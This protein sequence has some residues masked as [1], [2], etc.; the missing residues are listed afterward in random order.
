MVGRVCDEVGSPRRGFPV[1]I[2]ETI[3]GDHLGISFE[4]YPK[5]T[6]GAA[7]SPDGPC[8]FQMAAEYNVAAF[9]QFWHNWPEVLA[10]HPFILNNWAWDHFAFVSKTSGSRDFD[11]I[12]P[13]CPPQDPGA[14]TSWPPGYS[15]GAQRCGLPDLPYP[16]YVAL[17][18]TPKPL[19]ASLEPYRGSVGS[20]RGFLRRS[21]TGEPVKYG[22]VFTDGREFG[23]PSLFDGQYAI[24]DIPAGTYTLSVEKVGYRSE[25]TTVTVQEGQEAQVDF[26]LLFQGRKYPRAST[27]RTKA[28]AVA[29]TFLAP[30]WVRPSR[31]PTTWV[32]SNSL[33]AC[34]TSAT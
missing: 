20:I 19:P 6:R 3:Y 14:Q 12:P 25:S 1:M 24:N 4:G 15:E 31:L 16:Q 5:T 8:D 34:P 26:N 10:V 18:R 23:G 2:T 9:T 29:V 33:P 22:T 11:P 7:C 21:D 27:S 32:S 30:F 13:W 17:L 28:P